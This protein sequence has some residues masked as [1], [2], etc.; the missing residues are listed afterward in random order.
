M[1]V[2]KNESKMETSEDM[3]VYISDFIENTRN[4]QLYSPVDDAI[5]NKGKLTLLRASKK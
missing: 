4:I 1:L 5:R 2:T 3:S